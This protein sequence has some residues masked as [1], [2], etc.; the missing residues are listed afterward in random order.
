MDG[1]RKFTLF[2]AACVAAVSIFAW[3]RR[4]Q[5]AS[6]LEY[7]PLDAEHVLIVRRDARASA[8]FAYVD[9]VDKSGIRWERELRGATMFPDPSHRLPRIVETS[10][11]VAMRSLVSPGSDGL[12]NTPVLDAFDA[13]SGAALW[14]VEPMP[15]EKDKRG[16]GFNLLNLSLLADDG[17]VI[18]FFGRE[19]VLRDTDFVR[20]LAFDARTGAERWRSDVRGVPGLA[21]PA[22]VRGRSLVLLA[23][24]A[25][26]VID[27]KT[28][29]TRARFEAD[30]D[31]CVTS[32]HAWFTW[33]GELHTLSLETLSERTVPRP[34]DAALQ[35]HGGCAMRGG[36][37]WLAA[38]DRYGQSRTE[39][40][41]VAALAPAW[42]IALDPKDGSLQ[43][44][45]ELGRVRVGTPGDDR[46]QDTAPDTMPLSGD[47]PRY[48]PLTVRTADAPPRIVMLDLDA[49]RITW[50]TA[51]SERFAAG[52]W[53]RSGTRHYLAETQSHLFAAVDGE[54]GQ[55]TGAVTAPP[56]NVPK[57]AGG[58]VWIRDDRDVASVDPSTL[59]TLWS[60]AP[61]MIPDARAD[62][63]KLLAP[64]A[65]AGDQLH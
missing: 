24:N 42:M 18:A 51:P 14:H 33:N 28:G 46:G 7:E 37:L 43:A 34:L 59:R 9:L 31:P 10:G 55:L 58:R 2:V 35:L 13:R 27:T 57:L 52:Q 49:R 21:G 4:P 36:W 11:T 23:A 1:T 56:P 40:G 25:L 5:P 3:Y 20:V 17:L 47:A 26:V 65:D 39:S 16:M 45:F 19:L 30:A 12:R 6:I 54:T 44:Q 62:A 29:Q 15:G 53:R 64:Q 60:T 8:P 63:E 22:W 32:S 50:R 61:M 48:V 41:R 38:S